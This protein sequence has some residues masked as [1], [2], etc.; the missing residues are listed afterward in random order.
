MENLGHSRNV[1]RAWAHLSQRHFAPGHDFVFWLEDDFA[2]E[3]PLDLAPVVEVLKANP[4]LRQMAFLRHPVYRSEV[5]A[6]GVI[7]KDRGEYLH[8]T[9]GDGLGWYEH[10]RWFTLNPMVMP[11]SIPRQHHHHYPITPLHEWAFSRVLC[12]GDR[13]AQEARFGYWGD[14]APYTRHLSPPTPQEQ[15]R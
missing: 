2:F 8:V 14:G 11:R 9:D 13:D 1:K 3:R 15:K 4:Y 10:R 6:G 7:N 5:E 12:D